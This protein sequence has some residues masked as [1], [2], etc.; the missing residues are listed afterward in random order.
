MIPTGTEVARPSDPSWR[1]AWFCVLLFNLVYLAAIADVTSMSFQGGAVRAAWLLVPFLL[2][3][4]PAY[5]DAWM[6]LLAVFLLFSLHVVASFVVGPLLKGLAYSFWILVNYVLFYRTAYVLTAL[7]G[8]RV[9]NVVLLGG[10]VQ[11]LLGV[12]LFAFGVHE[13]TQFI[14]YEPSYLAIGLV[15]YLFCVLFWSRRRLVDYSL[16]GLVLV[17]NQSANL[18]LALVVAVALWF[19]YAR[20]AG[21]LL[22]LSLLVAAAAV[23]FFWAALSNPDNPNHGLAVWF[24]ENGWNPELWTEVGR[25]AGN[26]LPR[27]QAALE[28]LDGRWWFGLGPGNFPALTV[29]MDF[30]ALSGGVDYYDPAGLPVI[31]VFVEAAANAGILALLMV[32]VMFVMVFFAALR[33]HD[34]KERWIALGIVVAFCVMLQIESS[35]L[36]AYVWFSFGVLMARVDVARRALHPDSLDPSRTSVSRPA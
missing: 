2:F 3:L 1:E 7:L 35:Y 28:L 10:R 11:I 36:R 31:N 26:R 21:Q 25:R 14:Y 17:T 33:I 8:S 9:W 15:P 34:R 27:L 29:G 19:L 18:M 24:S 4:L 30:D 20:K 13:R 5:R 32:A 6:P 16:L 23:G 22:A 12:L